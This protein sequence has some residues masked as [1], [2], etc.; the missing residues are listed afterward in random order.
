M[1]KWH[2][3]SRGTVP[4]TQH[5]ADTLLSVTVYTMVSFNDLLAG[6]ILLVEDI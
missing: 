4:V 1:L 2:Y 3:M 6:S 5:H